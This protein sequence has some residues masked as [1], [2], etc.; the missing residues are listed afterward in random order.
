[1]IDDLYEERLERADFRLTLVGFLGM[2]AGPLFALPTPVTVVATALVTIGLCLFVLNMLLTIH[3][4]GPDGI[5]GVFASVL[6]SGA[7]SAT[8]G[9]GDP[10]VEGTPDR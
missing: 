4:H 5:A 10:D 8:A 1:M 3:R 7:G 6:E 2:A 9:G